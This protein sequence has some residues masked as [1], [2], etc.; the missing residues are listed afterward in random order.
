MTATSLRRPLFD[1]ALHRGR[2]TRAAEIAVLIARAEPRKLSALEASAAATL[3]GSAQRL[4]QR[5]IHEH[6][7]LAGGGHGI[8]RRRGRPN[9]TGQPQDLERALHR[10]SPDTITKCPM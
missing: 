7:A 5:S 6:S 8:D 1:R 4:D 10:P 9:R 3:E 2:C